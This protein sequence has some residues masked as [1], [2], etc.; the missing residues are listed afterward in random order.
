[1]QEHVLAMEQ[2]DV[3]RLFSDLAFGSQLK[4]GMIGSGGQWLQLHGGMMKCN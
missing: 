2:Y 1:M 3:Y 4:L